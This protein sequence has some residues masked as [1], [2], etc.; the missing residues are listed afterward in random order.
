MKKNIPINL[1]GIP[2]DIK[3]ST[4]TVTCAFSTNLNILNIGKFMDLKYDGIIYVGFGDNSHARSLYQ[5]TKK[6][7]KTKKNKRKTNFYNQAT[8]IISLKNNKTCNIKLFKNGAIQMTGCKNT[9]Q[10]FDALNI[11]CQELSKTKL[12]L[13]KN[14]KI[15][16]I[17][18]ADEPSEINIDKISKFE[19][20]MINSNF[21]T[22][23]IVNRAILYKLLL[24]DHYNSTFEP[25]THAGV[26]IKYNYKNIHIVSI[27]VFENGP[28][29]ITG[30]KNKDH[31]MEAYKFIIKY[32]YDHYYEIVKL[33]VELFLEKPSIKQIIKKYIPE[34]I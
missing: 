16:I 21:N 17:K 9:T 29:I 2:E 11:L 31:I 22:E 6:K 30:A 20:R 15:K 13:Y 25:C 7:Y 32:L 1:D 23:F 26:K 12:L 3:L 4:I 8:I 24:K 5:E 27:F 19:I 10:V 18:L 33:N 14:K 34:E 28:I